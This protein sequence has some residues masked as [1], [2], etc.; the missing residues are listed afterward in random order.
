MVLALQVE[1]QKRIV[2]HVD[3]GADVHMAA[4]YR[5]EGY[6]RIE[7]ESCFMANPCSS[8]DGST[9]GYS[10]ALTVSTTAGIRDLVAKMIEDRGDKE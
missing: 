3:P 9:V 8:D 1:A 4:E 6:H 10:N 2:R 7:G 5:K